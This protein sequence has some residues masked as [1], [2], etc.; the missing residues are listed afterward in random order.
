[1]M[2]RGGCISENQ[3]PARSLPPPERER[4]TLRRIYWWNSTE[5]SP[6]DVTNE[7]V[8]VELNTDF[9][10][11]GMA[12]QGITAIVAAWQA[13][14]ISRDMMTDLFRRGEVLPEGQSAKEEMKLIATAGKPTAATAASPWPRIFLPTLSPPPRLPSTRITEA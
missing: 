9:S 1:M 8:L 11:K 4:A 6:V 5:D 13:G 10:M 7:Q 3:W 14:A 2:A 12:P